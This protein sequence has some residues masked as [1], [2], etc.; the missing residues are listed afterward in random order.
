MHCSATRDRRELKF[1]VYE[2]LRQRALPSFCVQR[3][4]SP[5]SLAQFGCRR[6]SIKCPESTIRP[7]GTLKPS[8]VIWAATNKVLL[9]NA[10]GKNNEQ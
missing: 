2:R 1:S 8:G 5:E 10:T 4:L 6:F 3:L 9:S 7:V